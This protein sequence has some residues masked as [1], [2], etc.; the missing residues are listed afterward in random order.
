[1]DPLAALAKLG[2]YATRLGL[3]KQ[4]VSRRAL[5]AAVRDGRVLRV[6]HGVYAAGLPDGI[7][8][9]KVAVVALRGVVSHDSAAALWGLDLAH[10]PG[11]YVT[12]ARNRSRAKHPGIAVRRADVGET[13]VR[14][15]VRVTTPLRTVLDCA[16][17]LELACAVVVADSALRDGHLTLDELRTAAAAVRGRHAGKVRKMAALAD[18]RSGSV[19]ESLLRV[20][21]VEAGLGPDECQW[22]VRDQNARFVARVDFAYLSARLIVE[23][24]GFEFHRE[25]ADYRKD[26]RRANAYCRAD[27]SLLRFSWEDVRH[28]PD[29]V[30]DA[31]RH[32]LAKE[33]RLVRRVAVPMSTQKAA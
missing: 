12:V 10:Q 2:G 31:V 27:W 15:G 28:D 22:T 16:A 26:R 18:D 20:L 30:I 32:E 8:H 5:T 7:D 24:D 13:E 23:A 14:R 25:R 1:V 4:Q 29:Y 17:E 11:Q 21:L 19:L 3:M 33:P 6:R 9:L